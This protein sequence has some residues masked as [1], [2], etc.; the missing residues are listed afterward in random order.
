MKFHIDLHPYLEHSTMNLI[1][2]LTPW[3]TTNLKLINEQHILRLSTS[4]ALSRRYEQNHVT[5]TASYLWLV[6]QS[7]TN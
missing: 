3:R 1:Y 2:L 7:V 5:M 4:L 6:I